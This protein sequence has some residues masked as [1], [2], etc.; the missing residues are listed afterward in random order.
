MTRSV[1]AVNAHAHELVDGHSGIALLDPT[2]ELGGRAVDP[3]GDEVVEGE[4]RVAELFE[5]PDERPP[6]VVLRGGEEVLLGERIARPLHLP[7]EVGARSEGKPARASVGVELTLED[8]RSRVP[9]E[10]ETSGSRSLRR[11]PDE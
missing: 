5:S 4:P 9:R 11:R 7:G 6:D 3:H 8:D 10:L 2:G 1:A